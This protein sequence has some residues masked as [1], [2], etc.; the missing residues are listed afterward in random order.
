[1]T[2]SAWS[3]FYEKY[4]HEHLQY[5]T[6]GFSAAAELLVELKHL[7]LDGYKQPKP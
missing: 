5:R 3:N 1:M 6:N 4:N 7:P 2:Y